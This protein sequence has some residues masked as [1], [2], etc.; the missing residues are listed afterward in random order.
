MR[1]AGQ[2]ERRRAEFVDAALT[3][4]ARHG[5]GTTIQQI[6][7]QAGVAR[8][9]LYKHFTDAEDVHRAI[10][11][12]ASDLL[13]HELAPI[14]TEPGSA[15]ARITVGVRAHLRWI[16]EHSNLYFYSVRHAHS[17]GAGDRDAISDIK[18]TIAG[19]LSPMFRAYLALFGLDTRVAEPLGFG[20]AGLVESAGTRWLQHPN[21]IS[22]EELTEHLER[23]I[24]DIVDATLQAAGFRLDPHHPLPAPQDISP[25]HHT[26]PPTGNDTDGRGN[27]SG[28][29]HR[30]GSRRGP[31]S[32]PHHPELRGT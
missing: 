19:L 30:R 27:G 10:A 20:I 22:R 11:Q 4:I 25:P 31:G 6:A 5:P 17:L 23:W 28:P 13:T 3:A 9:G 7:R 18:T 8:T 2:R 26:N 12:R 16:T 15:A 1:W 32:C 21:R 29:P 24:W 14:W